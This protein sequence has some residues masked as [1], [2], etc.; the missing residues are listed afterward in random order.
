[1]NERM[2]VALPHSGLRVCDDAR[3][4]VF[5]MQIP[6]YMCMV[7][8]V[9]RSTYMGPRS[10]SRQGGWVGRYPSLM[11]IVTRRSS[12]SQRGVYVSTY[13]VR[14]VEGGIVPVLD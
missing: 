4:F 12:S 3:R 5:E 2:G 10:A 6:S 1:M 13:L 8:G 7:G 11:L 14:R 9:A